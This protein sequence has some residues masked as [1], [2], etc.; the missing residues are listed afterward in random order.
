M[1]VEPIINVYEDSS[2]ARLDLEP[3]ESENQEMPADLF[4][5]PKESDRD[6]DEMMWVDLMRDAI[7]QISSKTGKELGELKVISLHR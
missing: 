4:E 3:E 5:E 1:Q 7:T 6:K 2:F